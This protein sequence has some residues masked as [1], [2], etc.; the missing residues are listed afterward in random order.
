[1]RFK[2]CDILFVQTEILKQLE[3]TQLGN[4]LKFRN[5]NQ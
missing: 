3:N 1:M 2:H 5:L 4:A